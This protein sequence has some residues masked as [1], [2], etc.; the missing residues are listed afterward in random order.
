[1]SSSGAAPRPP[2]VDSRLWA[3]LRPRGYH[4]HRPLLSLTVRVNQRLW[5]GGPEDQILDLKLP[6]LGYAAAGVL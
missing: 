1:M 6:V 2:T 4:A 5:A 3:R